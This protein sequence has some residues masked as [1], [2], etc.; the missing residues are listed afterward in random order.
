MDSTPEFW[1]YLLF[2]CWKIWG[3]HFMLLLLD[4]TRNINILMQKLDQLLSIVVYVKHIYVEW[5]MCVL[6]L[7]DSHLHWAKIE[8]K[9][10]NKRAAFGAESIDRQP[11]V[12]GVTFTNSSVYLCN[13][14]QVEHMLKL[15]VALRA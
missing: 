7:D 2:A 5:K 11:A 1:I 13:H 14:R 12:S 6:M 15:L 9:R 8:L 4:S 10:A 3:K